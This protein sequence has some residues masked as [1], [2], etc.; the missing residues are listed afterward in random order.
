MTVAVE[1]HVARNP[2]RP[3]RRWRRRLALGVVVVALTAGGVVALQY[4][5]QI[6]SYLT[7][8][9]GSPTH[10]D[11][12]VAFPADDRPELRVAIV[13]DIGDSG[14]R[15]EATAAAMAAI[16]DDDPFDVLLLLGDNVYPSGDPARLP[17]T[18]FEPFADVLDDGTE[19]LAILGNH[20]DANGDAQ[21]DALGMPGRWWAQEYGDILLIGL[22][23]NEPNNPEQLAWLEATLQATTATW[24][25]VA[26]HHPPYS[27]GYQGS[28]EATRAAFTP[29]FRRYGVQ[30]V[31]SGHDHDYQRSKVIDGVTYIV[32]GAASGTRR[33]GEASFTEVSFSWHS[34]VELG[35]YPDRLIGRVMNQDHRVA[36]EWT[37]EP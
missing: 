13:G 28:N 32:T 14:G 19:L 35:I 10:T 29:L 26:V 24:R 3:R 23:S 20:D 2:A 7:H 5:R 33:T 12:Y 6:T 18:V 21:L 27:A 11:P 31:L 1:V 22:D 8:W 25:I 30:L 15:L 37:L 16:V 34:F 9:K 36:D 17:D 4:R